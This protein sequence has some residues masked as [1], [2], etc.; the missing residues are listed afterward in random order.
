MAL[1]WGIVS[2][3]LIASDFTTVLTSLP[4]SEHQVHLPRETL[5]LRK[6]GAS[7]LRRS[8]VPR[9][10]QEATLRGEGNAEVF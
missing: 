3:G 6:R 8:L 1:R 10:R 9:L 4:P 7:G 5:G 2:A